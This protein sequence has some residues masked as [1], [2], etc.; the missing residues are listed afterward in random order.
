MTLAA[1]FAAD[2]VAGVLRVLQEADAA[3]TAVEVKKALQASGVT[4]AAA[5]ESWPAVQKRIRTHEDIV[6]EGNRYRYQAQAPELSA[7]EALDVLVHEEL[8]APRKAQLAETV[9]AALTAAPQPDLETAARQRQA[10]VDAVKLLAELASEVEELLANET[11]PAVMI[12][13]VRAWVKRS[14]LDPVGRAGEETKFDR[15][16]HRPVDGQIRDGATVFVVRPGYIWKAPEKDLLIGKA[17]V[18]E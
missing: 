7:L 3:L 14:G 13:Q 6:V 9:R 11:E 18:E 17:V 10:Q 15:K 1:L 16:T 5:D 12:R 4:K 8:T 2:P